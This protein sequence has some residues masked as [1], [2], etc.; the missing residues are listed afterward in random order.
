MTE[1]SCPIC[2]ARGLR[3]THAWPALRGG[4]GM[5]TCM[6]E[7]GE[8]ELTI[9]QREGYWLMCVFCGAYWPIPHNHILVDVR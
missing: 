4:G 1:G 6:C 7:E 3:G 9:L 5:H 2:L 8:Q